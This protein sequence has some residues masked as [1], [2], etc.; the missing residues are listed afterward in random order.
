[1]LRQLTTQKLAGVYLRVI[2]TTIGLDAER[3]KVH[4]IYLLLWCAL[5]T[6]ETT[7]CLSIEQMQ[8]YWV[9]RC[10]SFHVCGALYV[11]SLAEHES[12]R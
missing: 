11:Q 12:A 3:R 6:H 4:G 10:S 7:Q 2:V 9:A 1:M 5:A 8:F